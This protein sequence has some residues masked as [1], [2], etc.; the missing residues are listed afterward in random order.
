MARILVVEDSS[1]LR[2]LLAILLEEEGHEVV[3]APN[4]TSARA[5]LASGSFDLVATD[6]SAD[7]PLGPAP[8]DRA[9]LIEAGR[10]SIVLVL[11][12]R[13]WASQTD[14]RAL[15]VAAI[16]LKPFDLRALVATIEQ[17]LSAK[18]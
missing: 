12:G 7:D 11:T 13:A 5:A 18:A 6:L 9:W 4:L 15:G 17:L 16:V 3:S 2:N 10:G 14:P 1:E 8:E